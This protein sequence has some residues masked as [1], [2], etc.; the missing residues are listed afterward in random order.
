MAVYAVHHT[1]PPPPFQNP[2]KQVQEVGASF[3]GLAEKFGL[4]IDPAVV[5]VKGR[6]LPGPKITVRGSNG[7][8]ATEQVR[9]SVYVHV[10]CGSCVCR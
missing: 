4:K 8:E 5:R 9:G 1:N 3:P 2:T 10:V 7:R 6:F